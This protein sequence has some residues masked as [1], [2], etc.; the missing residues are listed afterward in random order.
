MKNEN[1][2]KQLRKILMKLYKADMSMVIKRGL[3]Q[4]KNRI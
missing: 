3:A 4:K 2:D 1:F